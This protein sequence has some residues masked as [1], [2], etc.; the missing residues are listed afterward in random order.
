MVHRHV[1]KRI[2][3]VEWPGKIKSDVSSVWKSPSFS[4]DLQVRNVIGMLSPRLYIVDMYNICESI[5][6][7]SEG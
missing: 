4:S 2:S 1:T 6:V 5:A 7:D 3:H